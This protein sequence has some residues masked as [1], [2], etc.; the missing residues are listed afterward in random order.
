MCLMSAFYGGQ[1]N[2]CGWNSHRV[3]SIVRIIHLH[4]FFSSSMDQWLSM[5]IDGSDSS[6]SFHLNSLRASIKELIKD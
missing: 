4:G 2:C 5:F 6:L 3:S 1:A